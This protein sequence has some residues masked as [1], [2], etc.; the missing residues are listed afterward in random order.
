MSNT[1]RRAAIMAVLLPALAACSDSL[2]PEPIAVSVPD[3]WLSPT[4]DGT[5]MSGVLR[6]TL[7]NETTGYVSIRPCPDV[8]ERDN[9]GYASWLIVGGPRICPANLAPTFV[10]PGESAILSVGVAL[11]TRGVEPGASWIRRAYRVRLLLLDSAQREL[12]APSNAFVIGV[13]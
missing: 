12:E 3:T 10:G 1:H 9:G 5:K 8:V 4:D 7:T 13:R 2:A 6:L 11:R